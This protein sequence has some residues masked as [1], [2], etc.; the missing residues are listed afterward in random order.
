MSPKRRTSS[1]VPARTRPISAPFPFR[2]RGGDRGRLSRK[3][4]FLYKLTAR[5]YKRAV[6]SYSIKIF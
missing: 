5:Y 3:K 6:F 4:Q 2:G 1:A